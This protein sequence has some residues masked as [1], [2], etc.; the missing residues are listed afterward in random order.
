MP[1]TLVRNDSN[2][3]SSLTVGYEVVNRKS[4]RFG[5]VFFVIV[6]RRL[7]A[8]DRT[9]AGPINGPGAGDSRRFFPGGQRGQG[10]Y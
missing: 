3:T 8:H 2:Q 5:R 4:P 9:D 10:C 1:H 7:T 6:P